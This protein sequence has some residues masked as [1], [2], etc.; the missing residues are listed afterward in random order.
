MAWALAREMTS[1]S[2]KPGVGYSARLV[3]PTSSS[4]SGAFTR[5]VA[6]ARDGLAVP[7]YVG[8]RWSPRHVVLVLPGD[9]GPDSVLVYD[10]A[11]GRRY[12]VTRDD[13]VGAALDVAGWSSPWVVVT[14]G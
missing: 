6:C 7:L 10:P 9:E 12:P 3:L 4:R 13:F 1:Q 14:P 8:N 2:G 5:M 11:R